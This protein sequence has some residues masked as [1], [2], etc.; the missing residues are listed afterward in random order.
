MYSS[1]T[2]YVIYTK[3]GCDFC[4]KLKN[5]LIHEKKTFTEI[6]CDNHIPEELQL[7]LFNM[8]EN[9]GK[10]WKTFPIVFVNGT[11]IGGYTETVKYIE[12]QHAFSIFY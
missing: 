12:R 1:E 9:T 11:F 4:R 10:R 5:L 8:Q 3:D 7:F 6:N 2:E